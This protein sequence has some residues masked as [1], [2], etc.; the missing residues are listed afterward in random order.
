MSKQSVVKFIEDKRAEGKT[1]SQITHTLLEAGWH[2]DII[3]KVVHGEPIKSLGFEPV[4]S[5]KIEEKYKKIIFGVV[6]IFIVAILVS[7]LFLIQ[8]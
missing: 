1:D 7:F 4:I 8:T 2:I 5:P 6:I 3:H